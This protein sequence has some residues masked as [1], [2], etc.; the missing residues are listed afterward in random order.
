MAEQARQ[1]RGER[2]GPVGE[3]WEGG[4]QE[5]FLGL[6]DWRAMHPKATLAEIEAELDRR[7]S[8]LRAQLLTDLALAS[9]AADL[10][11]GERPRC[12]DCGGSLYDEGVRARTLL[13]T[14]HAP[15][16]LRRDYATCVECGH[17]LFP[18]GR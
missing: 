18:P 9:A 3:Q 11:A 8:G 4:V 13:T 17:R 7:L 16:T 6:R 1:Q 2:R 14:G 10:A 12:P 15:V 5:V